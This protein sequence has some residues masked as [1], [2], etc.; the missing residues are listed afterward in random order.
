[1]DLLDSRGLI[2]L[3]GTLDT[4]GEEV[5]FLRQTLSALGCDVLVIDVGV[6]GEPTFAPEVTRE[7]IAGKAGV[8]IND[9][10]ARGDRGV[11]IE[12]MGL[13]LAAW[14]RTQQCSIA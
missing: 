13:G 2:A 6:Q 10:V 1:M 14:F 3:I 7:K 9:L 5:L 12:T 11:A 4:K 8:R